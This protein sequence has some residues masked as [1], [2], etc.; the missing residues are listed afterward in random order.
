MK[1]TKFFFPMSVDKAMEHCQQCPRKCQS[2]KRFC[3]ADPK[4]PEA[5]AVYAHL[6]EEP[7]LSGK[8]GIS[9]IFFA[10]CNLQCCYCQNNAISRAV[11]APERITLRGIKS[12]IDATA[13]SLTHTE[14]IV[15]LVSATHYAD[16]VPAIV[17]GLHTRGLF[18]TIV[19]NTGGYERV[20]VLQRLAPYIDIYLPDFKYADPALALRYSK[21]ADYPEV[22]G[23][24]L[25]EMY[26]Q[27]GSA[28]PTDDDGLAFRGLIVRHL[29]LPGQVDNSIRC[30][31][32]IADNLSVNIHISLMA[33]YF[34]P[35]GIDLPDQLGRR[36]NADEYR[37]V[38]EAFNELGFHRGWVQSCDAADN[39][40][41][42]FDNKTTF[43]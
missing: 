27:K 38:V 42:H 24:A 34:P 21:A 23:R 9:N 10:H 7:P 30:L 12:I 39:Y 1:V 22:A 33:Q 31:E 18:P 2:L 28:L 41:P 4:L 13:E 25:R 43:K 35:E 26:N 37:R 20:E 14:N 40:K 16:L 5:A 3:N 11:V 29:V 36:L 15:G 17:E 19:Y 6:G 8:K 32:W